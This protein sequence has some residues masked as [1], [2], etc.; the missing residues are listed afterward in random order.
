[1]I[2]IVFGLLAAVTNASQAL[3]SRRLTF[4]YP[5]RQLIGVLYVLNCC[6]LLPF[7]P[8]VPWHWSPSTAVLHLVSAG[9]MVATA[10]AIWDMFDRGEASSVTTASALSPISAAVF[11]A[12][13]LPGV[14][15][16]GQAVAAVFVTGG[17][18][19]GL[20]SAFGAVGRWWVIWRIIVAAGGN[21]LLT[22]V[23]KLQ[24]DLHVGVVETYVI[25]TGI[26][27]VVCLL[28][29]PPRD[30]PLRATPRLF[31]RSLLVTSS[32]IF[33]ILGVQQGSPVVVQTLVATTPLFALAVESWRTRTPPPARALGAALL[34]V[35]GVAVVLVA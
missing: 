31:V 29:F 14:F 13:L 18:L 15:Q 17:V 16:P 34:V 4:H 7:A 9:L 6:V 33:I 22:V 10:I 23:V 5:A 24:S 11:S 12:V 8:F 26:A 28:L 32:F 20:G 19:W 25:R 27:A 2:A 21:G 30:V 1:M 35:A 3:V